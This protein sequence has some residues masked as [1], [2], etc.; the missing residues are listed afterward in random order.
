MNILEL[1]K[2]GLNGKNYAFM[3]FLDSKLVS[4]ATLNHSKIWKFDETDT[5]IIN[6]WRN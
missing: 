2:W 3:M 6:S 1:P 5:E 4:K